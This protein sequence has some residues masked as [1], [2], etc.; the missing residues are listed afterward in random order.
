[1]EAQIINEKQKNDW[2]RYI[3]ENVN[4]IAW[5]AY[6]WSQIIREHFG[7]RFFP[8]AVYDGGVI[9]GILPLYR[10]KTMIGGTRMM[11]VPHAVAGGIL[12]DDDNIGDCLLKKGIELA[13]DSSTNELVLKQYKLK[14]KGE[15]KVD[16]NYFNRELGLSSGID[17]IWASISGYNKEQIGEID[18]S[19]LILDHPSN[20]VDEFYRL[21]LTHH[22]R[23][24]IPCVSRKWIR[25]LVK[26][27]MY[28]IALL[29]EGDRI[30]SGTMVKTFKDTVSFPFTCLTGNDH[31][32]FQA[33]YHL[34][35]ELIKKFSLENYRIFHSGRIPQSEETDAYRLGWG[36]VKF[37]YYYQYYP[38]T[39]SQTEFT[40]KR[41][42]KRKYFETIWRVTPRPLVKS[43]GPLIVKQFP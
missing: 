7:H 21:V 11:S 30:Q 39:V 34:Y 19:D 24:G 22:H 9:R 1:M 5:Q 28:S 26:F 32:S 10:V 16:E 13:E 25:D 6:D 43:V 4:S 2:N 18:G 27:G 37:P 35:W 29:R 42:S 31:Q 33:A 12:A 20:K 38:K 3:N 14:V 36:G 17:D 15:L 23:R 40:K 41:G 8:I